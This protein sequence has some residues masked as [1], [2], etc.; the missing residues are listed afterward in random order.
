VRFS[1]SLSTL[2]GAVRRQV[3]Q[4]PRVCEL[5]NT[6]YCIDG[7]ARAGDTVGLKLLHDKL[8]F[9]PHANTTLPLRGGFKT[10]YANDGGR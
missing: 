4:R 3:D 6:I 2:F 10:S 7:Y 8:S 9:P 5:K 1:V